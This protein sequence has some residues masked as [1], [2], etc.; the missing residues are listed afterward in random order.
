MAN[1]I[2]KLGCGMGKKA[3]VTYRGK[4]K[5]CILENFIHSFIHIFS[6]LAAPL[7]SDAVTEQTT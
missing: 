2:E 5:S 1:Y 3:K 4:G 7:V 6:A